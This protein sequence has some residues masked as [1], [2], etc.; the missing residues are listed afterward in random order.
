MLKTDFNS[1]YRH[2]ALMQRYR[3]LSLGDLGGYLSNG[4]RS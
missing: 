1:I 2:E 4:C 3:E